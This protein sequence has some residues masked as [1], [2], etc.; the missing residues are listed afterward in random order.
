MRPR[1]LCPLLGRGNV[2]PRC[3][4]AEAVVLVVSRKVRQRS[5]QAETIRKR[6]LNHGNSWSMGTIPINLC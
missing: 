3:S 6:L 5:P 2:R 4:R 1:F